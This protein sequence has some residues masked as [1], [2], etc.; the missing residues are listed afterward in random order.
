[1]AVNTYKISELPTTTTISNSDL[2]VIVD[3]VANLTRKITAQQMLAYITGSSFSSL[4][5][6]GN[7]NAT[8]FSGNG[9]SITNITSSNIIN[10]TN[11]VR[12]KFSA[13]T[14]INIASGLISANNVPNSV[15]QNSS[16][17]LGGTN[18]SLGQ[19]STTIVGLT[20]ITSSNVTGTLARFTNIT[21]SNITGSDAKYLSLTSSFI[22]SSII[23]TTQITA[24]IVSA[25]SWYGL[26]D[27]LS[28]GGTTNGSIQYKNGTGLAATDS[29]LWDTVNNNLSVTG[30]ISL[31]G[32]LRTN[33]STFNLLNTNATTINFGAVAETFNVGSTSKETNFDLRGTGST[34]YRVYNYTS[35]IQD[36]AV[37]SEYKTAARA[38]TAGAFGSRS[39]FRTQYEGTNGASYIRL[40]AGAENNVN[41]QTIA[42]LSTITGAVFYKN[43]GI[44][45]TI[46]STK[47]HVTDA[48]SSTSLDTGKFITIS[49][50]NNTA[51]A[52]HGLAFT[53]GGNSTSGIIISAVNNASNGSAELAI[54]SRTLAGVMQDKLTI[55]GDSG[56]VNVRLGNIVVGTA[57]KGIDFSATSNAAGMTS[58]VLADYEEGTWTPTLDNSGPATYTSQVGRYVKVGKT[59]T[60]NFRIVVSSYVSSGN[61]LTISG[62]PFTSYSTNSVYSAGSINATL[63]TTAIVS[64]DMYLPSGTTT[65]SLRKRTAASANHSSVLVSDLSSTTTMYGTIVYTTNS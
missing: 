45:E 63:L 23:T 44:G 59:V 48:N 42:T 3:S 31:S 11:D 4:N 49:N 56:D 26:P 19:T 5:V 50:S 60:A 2:L 15:L 17:T 40:M 9:N 37:I 55:S 51:N 27:G 64:M 28:P 8:T 33:S 18:I 21:S 24:S 16:I 36:G 13:G 53:C 41:L 29:L 61:A 46:P 54:Q 22:S 58:E 6:L 47:L 57:G 25:S 52:R 43:V 65:L 1:M 30:N 62:L 10:F 20:T 12:S 39:T 35:S 7:A 38:T 34:Y 14:G 32:D